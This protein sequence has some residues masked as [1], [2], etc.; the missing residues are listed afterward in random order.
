VI[1]GAEARAELHA[2]LIDHGVADGFT[3]ER[4]FRDLDHALEWCENDLL[5]TLRNAAVGG[6]HPF[7]GLDLLRDVSPE[8]REV[9]RAALVWREYA[10][11]EIVF[12]QGDDGDALYV[13]ARG[14]ASVWLRD[15]ASGQRRLMTFS[16]GTF[17]GEM[18]LLDQE[19]RSATLTADE[20][21]ACYVLDR[22]AFD[23]LREAHPR[24]GMALLANL[25]RELSLRMRGA[26]RTLTELA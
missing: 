1:C 13:I 2:L 3:R 19:R 26:N 12:R 11:G 9:L 16:Q 22:A 25:G 4:M 7:D 18:A 6:D 17:F 14:S 21:L 15:A 8:D 5:A 24:A 20:K 23:R 10:P